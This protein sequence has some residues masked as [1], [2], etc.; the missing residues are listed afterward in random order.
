VAV[1]TFA[2]TLIAAIAAATARETY[3]VHMY[4][5]GRPE[6]IAAPKLSTVA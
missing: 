3:N 1:F 6:A 2:A 4:E 5:L